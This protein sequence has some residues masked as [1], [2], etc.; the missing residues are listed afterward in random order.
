VMA[1]GYAFGSMF[2]W[3]ATRRRRTILRLGLV[4][5]ALFFVLRAANVY[6]DP[7]P[8][9]AQKNPL[10]TFFSFI[11]CTKYPP[12]LLYLL[13]TLGPALIILACLERET[14]RFL[15]PVLV[16]GRVPLFYYLLHLP[17][18]HGLAVLVRQGGPG[19]N[20]PVVYAVWISVIGVLYPVCRWFANVKRRRR[21]AWLSYL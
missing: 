13:M 18:I 4:L 7:S 12:S 1:A 11:N 3:E 8:W 9:S 19:Y 16:F 15:Q 21:E 20:L 14:P 2:R 17:L 5:T 10:Y 6:G